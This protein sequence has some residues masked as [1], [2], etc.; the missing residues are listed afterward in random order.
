MNREILLWISRRIPLRYLALGA[1]LSG[2]YFLV[3]LAIMHILRTD[4]DTYSSPISHY[5]FSDTSLYL[6]S[7]FLLAGCGEVVLA[8]L[9]PLGFKDMNIWGRALLFL[10]G[11]GALLVGFQRVGTIHLI[12]ALFQAICFPVGVLLLADGVEKGSF[13][14][15]SQLTSFAALTLL[16]MLVVGFNGASVMRPYFG[17]LEKMLALVM[18]SWSLVVLGYLYRASQEL[19]RI[20]RNPD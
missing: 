9:L 14:R 16:P 7:G 15:Y 1:L 5:Y 2:A 8:A 19:D 17:L 18:M 13:K 11:F 6:V 12:G 4:L 10:A 3:V 20:A